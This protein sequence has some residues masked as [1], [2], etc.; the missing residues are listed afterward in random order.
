M[1]EPVSKRQYAILRLETS[2][3]IVG[4]GET[5]AIVAAD[6]AQ[7]AVILRG[8]QATEYAALH[9][10]LAALPDLHAAA[11]MALLDIVG[12]APTISGRSGSGFR[13]CAW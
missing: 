4:W 9:V 5:P 2:S 7:A 12:K 13:P 1:W 8:R 10:Q 6:L 3:G 11:N